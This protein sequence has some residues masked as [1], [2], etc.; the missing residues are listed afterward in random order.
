MRALVTGAAGFVG[1]WLCQFLLNEGIEVI[2]QVEGGRFSALGSNQMPGRLADP[3]FCKMLTTDVDVVFHLAS[4]AS[5]ARF[6]SAPQLTLARDFTSLTNVLEACVLR[7]PKRFVY[8]SSALIYETTHDCPKI[9]SS[10][11]RASSFYASSKISGEALVTA[12]ADSSDFDFVLARPFN[13]YGHGQDPSAVVAEFM[14]MGRQGEIKVRNPFPVRDFIHVSDLCR[15]LLAMAKSNTCGNQILNVGTGIGRTIG[16]VA[17]EISL[18]F[19]QTG[20]RPRIALPSPP[21]LSGAEPQVE[22]L[23]ADISKIRDTLNWKPRIEFANGIAATIS[24]LSP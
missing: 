24:H 2:A 9:E 22:S 20:K 19:Q 18:A 14:Q 3:A 1:S 10:P 11:T 15:A 13:V 5:Q 16:E 6:M 17:E 21:S 23:V 8:I 12:Y 7:P 4:E